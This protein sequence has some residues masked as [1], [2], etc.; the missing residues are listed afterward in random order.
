MVSGQDR[1]YMTGADE[2]KIGWWDLVTDEPH[3]ET[4]EAGAW[5]GVSGPEGLWEELTVQSQPP[6]G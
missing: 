4:P 5:G 1:L 3:P 6:L 2:V